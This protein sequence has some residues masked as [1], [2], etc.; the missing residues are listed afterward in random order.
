MS[1]RPLKPAPQPSSDK[2]KRMRRLTWKVLLL[3]MCVNVVG[4][5]WR[6]TIRTMGSMPRPQIGKLTVPADVGE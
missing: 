6:M 1:R 4:A 3:G 5:T 2:R